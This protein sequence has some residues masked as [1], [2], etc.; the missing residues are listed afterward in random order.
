MTRRVSR[1]QFFDILFCKSAIRRLFF[2]VLQHSF[3]CT[4][5][6]LFVPCGLDW[7][8]RFAFA[9]HVHSH[10]LFRWGRLPVI[11]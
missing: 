7:G 6:G 10:L 9:V 3:F 2:S 5:S 11:G 8:S 4:L 1:V